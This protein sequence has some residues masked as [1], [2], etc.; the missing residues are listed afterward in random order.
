[1]NGK[2]THDSRQP[3]TLAAGPARGRHLR[4]PL[5]ASAA[6]QTLNGEG[7]FLEASSQ[8]HLAGCARCT[9]RLDA[10]RAAMADQRDTIVE[11]ADAAFSDTRLRAQRTSILDRLA[12]DRASARVLRFPAADTWAARG[13][14]RRDRPAMRWL[15][16]AAAAG[17][18]VGLGAGQIV[19]T[20]RQLHLIPS[21]SSARAWTPSRWLGQATA[22]MPDATM[23]ERVSPAA[24]EQF[25]SEMEL[26]INRRRNAALRA[27]STD[28]APRPTRAS[29]QTSSTPQR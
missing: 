20:G 8:A 10:L 5:L 18:L 29:H 26:A 19:F 27:L 15:A 3:W 25:L 11:A 7:P 4:E 16:G 2:T 13:W 23:I 17:L 1:M 22:T 14:I 9:A 12:R 24:E 28:L 6:L 21:A